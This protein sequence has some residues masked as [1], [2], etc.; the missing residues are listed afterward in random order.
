LPLY[1]PSALVLL[2]LLVA[3]MV[4]GETQYRTQLPWW[5]VLVHVTL[6]ASVWAAGVALVRLLWRPARI[7]RNA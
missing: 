3:Q 1:L 7:T 2:G 6:A 5:L 4:V